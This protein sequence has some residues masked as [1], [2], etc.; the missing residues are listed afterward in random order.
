LD[1]VERDVVK[2]MIDL[3]VN[4]KSF[5]YENNFYLSCDST[6]MAKALSHYM[7][8]KKTIEIAGS[9]V[10]CGVFKGASFSMLSMY[11]KLHNLEEKWMIGFDSFGAFPE[12]NYEEDKEVRK[13]F[14]SGAGD[15]SISVEQ[16]HQVLSDKKCGDNV[17]L[18]KG[19]ISETVP[20]FI[21]QNPDLKISLL[22]LDV[23][24]YEPSVT[25]LK[26]LY[27]LIT[28]GGV[29]I[30]D[31]YGIA[32]GETKAVDEYFDHKDATIEESLFPDTSQ[33]II[34]S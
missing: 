26:Y 28:T 30:L 27:P 2:R 18:V 22:I 1:S 31:D 3:P 4:E 20:K 10:E 13:R 21:N 15:Q 16:L 33:Y 9:I 19:D 14:I 8:F 6:R 17:T 25:I 29:L 32:P 23:D 12:A 11:R 7:L 34:K 24:I 5:E